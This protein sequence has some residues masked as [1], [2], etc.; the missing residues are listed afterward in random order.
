MA[1]S[2]ILYT[3]RPR[4]DLL[5]TIQRSAKKLDSIPLEQPFTYLT[6]TRADRLVLLTPKKLVHYGMREQDTE[7][8]SLDPRYSETSFEH[9]RLYQTY[10]LDEA[11]YCVPVDEVSAACSH[12]ITFGDLLHHREA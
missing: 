1:Q 9:D 8:I 12:H 5:I 4:T 2:D 11:I 6:P 3:R 10:S 7:T